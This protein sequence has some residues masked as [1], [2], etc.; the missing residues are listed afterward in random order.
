MRQLSAVFLMFSSALLGQTYTI[1]TFAGG[2]PPDN[3][4]GTS[5]GLSLAANGMAA[6]AAG[7]IF[8]VS[9]NAVFRLD[10]ASGTVKPARSMRHWRK[11]PGF[12]G[13]GDNGP[14]TSAQLSYPTGVAVDPAGNN[15]YF[16][17]SGNDRIRRVANGVITTVAG[18]GDFGGTGDDGPATS[19]QLGDPEG[20]AVDSAGNL[21]IADTNNN[22][23]RRVSN[24]VITTVAGSG[25]AGSIGDGGPAGTARLSNPVAVAVDSAGNLYIA[26]QGNQRIREVSNGVITSVP[27]NGIEAQSAIIARPPAAGLCPGR[28]RCG[29]GRQPLRR[30][31]ENSQPASRRSRTGWS[32]RWWAP[33]PL[34]SAATMARPAAPC[35]TTPLLSRSTPL[36]TFTLRTRG[37]FASAWSRTA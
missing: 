21:Y 25:I 2:G 14:A 7:N 24:G 23:V 1:S 4:P 6:D 19:A 5:M 31:P 15:L 12:D 33:E 26:D 27:G 11:S 35:W 37:I 22:R 3:V 13:A 30:G 16:S 20:L 28:Y 10:H 36:G 18:N 29:R 34:D 17:D 8:F 9:A 32:P